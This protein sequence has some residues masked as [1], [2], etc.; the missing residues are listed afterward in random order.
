MEAVQGPLPLG[1][2][3][4]E[5]YVIESLLGKGDFG[6]VYLARDRREGHKSF[7]LAEL[8]NPAAGESYHFT[9]NYVSRTPLDRHMLPRAQYV[10]TDS[11]LGRTYLLMNYIEEPNLELLRLQQ[12][13]QRFPVS[14]VLSIMTPVANALN[15]LH[16][17]HPPIVHG[18]MTPA[19]VIV[20]QSIDVPVLVMLD[21]FKEHE[22]IITPLPYF[23][24]GYGASE[25][26]E[27][28]CSVRSDVYGLGAIYY[29]LLTGLIPPDAL[30]RI[31]QQNHGES[32]P[33]QSAHEVNSAVPA[34]IAEIIQQAMSLDPD[35]RF[36]SVEQFH[37][38]MA[39]LAEESPAE[40]VPESPAIPPFLPVPVTPEPQEP[41]GPRSEKADSAYPG[42]SKQPDEEVAPVPVV[43]RRPATRG[44][45]M[46]V[47][48]IWLAF[49][50]LVGVG[51][52][53]WLHV[54]HL[55][56]VHTN[57]PIST[58]TRSLPAPTPTASPVPS[59]YA[60]LAGS[61]RGTIYD[62]S[63]NVSTVMSLTDIR[64]NQN[65]FSGYLIL[66]PN[67]QGS[68]P[69]KGSIDAKKHIQFLV[70]DGA[71]SPR[72]FFEGVMQSPTAL[73]GDYYYCSPG[74]PLQGDRC[75]RASGSYGLWN[76]I[77]A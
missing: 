75:T 77:L 62:V 69:F 5:H 38:K 12:S 47:L 49:L 24:P 10:Y 66:G 4:Y 73:T 34:S 54:Q 48:L 37:S 56:P 28:Q 50:L 46:R 60:T 33:L 39:A 36:S 74:G 40:M 45:R 65:Q 20:S 63:V 64:Q 2:I 25:Q 72:L 42:A 52:D 59:L 1:T 8:L 3:I 35:E 14:Q 30:Y 76:V 43:E 19:C 7:A 29:T 61:Y 26:Y 68:G 51:A 6:N 31:T 67:V 9:L 70:M 21:L 44:R 23:A 13:E 53:F 18:K 15:H 55:P 16:Q 32:D 22:A 17:H 11:R 57:V 41:T 58:V 27:G 71:G